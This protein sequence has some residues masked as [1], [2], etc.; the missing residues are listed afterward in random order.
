MLFELLILNKKHLLP[1]LFAKH[2]E[3]I[4]FFKRKHLLCLTSFLMKSC[5]QKEYL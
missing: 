4:L 2:S 5:I 3:E 1:D